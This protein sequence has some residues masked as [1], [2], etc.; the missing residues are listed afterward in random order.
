MTILGHK[1]GLHGSRVVPP[2]ASV[3]LKHGHSRGETAFGS[4]IDVVNNSTPYLS[5]SEKFLS[6]QPRRERLQ[7]R[8]TSAFLSATGS[9][10]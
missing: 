5:D 8:V 3:Y 6:P 1:I 2:L 7:S 4:M 9:A 10:A